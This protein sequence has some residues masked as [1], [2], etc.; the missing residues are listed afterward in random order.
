MGGWSIVI[1]VLP[2]LYV[3]RLILPAF[4]VSSTPLHIVQNKSIIINGTRTRGSTQTPLN[5]WSVMFDPHRSKHV[6]S[7]RLCG[8][9]DRV[10]DLY[11][12]D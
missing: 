4:P 7:Y 9:C 1:A 10:Y 5:L 8:K 3:A 12:I 6:V 2:Y 11:F